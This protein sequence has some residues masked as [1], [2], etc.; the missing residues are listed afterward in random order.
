MAGSPSGPIHFRPQD[1]FS[2]LQCSKG[3][4]CAAPVARNSA[5]IP[6]RNHSGVRCS[7]KKVLYIFAFTSAEQEIVAAKAKQA[8]EVFSRV[9]WGVAA[10]KGIA[11]MSIDRE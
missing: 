11:M 10:I 8:L 2:L 1:H 7:I 3:S 5:A 4:A 9:I 6:I